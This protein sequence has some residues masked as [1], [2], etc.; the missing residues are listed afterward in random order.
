MPKRGKYRMEKQRDMEIQYD[1]TD[2]FMDMDFY[3][4]LDADW[5]GDPDMSRSTSGFVFITSEEQ[6]PG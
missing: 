2:V 6:S 5:S 4:Y 1:G 3:G